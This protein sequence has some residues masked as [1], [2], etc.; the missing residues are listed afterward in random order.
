MLSQ[1][2][3]MEVNL[4]GESAATLVRFCRCSQHE[5]GPLPG[6]RRVEK[7]V[8]AGGRSWRHAP[9][10]QPIRSI[11]QRAFWELSSR[12]PDGAIITSD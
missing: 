9:C 8:A 2:Y 11:P 7:N 12:L 1:R 3:P 5:D 10:V 4:L 6:D